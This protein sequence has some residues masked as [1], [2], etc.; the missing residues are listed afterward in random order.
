[1]GGVALQRIQVERV[2][3]IDGFPANHTVTFALDG[4]TYEID[5][6]DEHTKQLRAV[7]DRYIKAAR[8]LN[9]ALLTDLWVSCASGEGGW[10]AAE[11]E[12]G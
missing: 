1:M 2:D 6:N 7:L 11:G 8:T 5:L 10:V 4:V 3:D 9:P 12:H